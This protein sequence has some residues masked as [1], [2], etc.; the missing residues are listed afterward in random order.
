MIFVVKYVILLIEKSGDD[1]MFLDACF[2]YNTLNII[3][4]VNSILD[5]VYFI[6]PM[7]AIVIITVDFAKSVVSSSEEQMKKNISIVIK[8][9][10]TLIILFIIPNIINLVINIANTKDT[11]WTMYLEE[12]NY[13]NVEKYK[14]ECEEEKKIKEEEMNNKNERTSSSSRTST[15]KIISKSSKKSSSGSS[16]SQSSNTNTNTTQEEDLEEFRKTAKRV[17]KE[18]VT[19]NRHFTYNAYI[20]NDIP[21]TNSYCDCSSYV[22]WVLYE[23]GYEDFKGKQKKTWDFYRKDWKKK[24]GWTVIKVKGGENVT[25]KVKKGDILV[26]IG[27]TR[28]GTYEGHIDIVAN[29]KKKNGKKTIV[30]YDCGDSGFV[31]N[32]THKNGVKEGIRFFFETDVRPGKIIR[33]RKP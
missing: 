12:S 25:N 15:K 16:S 2:D 28:K 17:W 9:I 6:V 11:E 23:Y 8:R 21:I 20:Y 3:K 26:R 14:V 7:L 31:K 30:A 18:I 10:V 22:S 19:G 29:I 1:A 32:G 4:F 33:V 5:I 13:N 27:Y 24:Y